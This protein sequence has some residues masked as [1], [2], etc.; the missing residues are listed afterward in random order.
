MKKK[1]VA[2]VLCVCMALPLVGCGGS[3]SKAKKEVNTL[4]VMMVNSGW[5]TAWV[6]DLADKF[7]ELYADEG[8]K[9]NILPAKS[10]FSGTSALSEIRL[11]YE[12]TGYDLVISSGY[13]VQQVTDEEYGVAVEPLTDVMTS[14]PINFDGSLGEAT[15]ESLYDNSQSW[16]LK[17]DD[18]YWAVPYMS[19]SRGL[20]CNMKVLNKYGITEMPV[21]TDEL[22]ECFDTVYNGV[23]D[24]AGMRPVVWGG[25]NAYGYA[26][27]TFYNTIAQ[28][29]G[30]EDYQDFFTLNHL[31]NDD[32]TIKA[33]GYNHLNNEAVKEAIN[34]AMH[35]FDVAYSL[36]GSL[37]QNHTKA[38]ASIITGKAAFMFDGNFF[39]NEVRTS[40]PSYL[41]DVRFSLLPIASKL[42]V[43]LQ[44]DGSG[45][46][47][48]KCDEILS[49]MAKQ[50]DEGKSAAEI[51]TTTEAQFSIALTDEKVAR[52][53]EARRTGNGDDNVLNI[54]KGSPNVEIAKLFIRMMLSEDAAKEVYVKYGMCS[55]TYSNIEV[56][57]EYQ[58]ITDSY[59]ALSVTDF[60]TT[61]TLYPY[62]VRAKTNLFLI[63]PYNAK[64]AVTFK[65]E[66]GTVDKATDRNY[67][68][69]T[70]TIFNKVTST[71]QKN[72]ATYMANG[73]Y[74]IG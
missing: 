11:G 36:A 40:F 69:L 60:R 15:I 54:I 3:E 70:E 33:D 30:R 8:Y 18:T 35:S 9:V 64:F 51:K 68:L 32:G 12:K 46:D 50:V 20:V 67:E 10:T 59:K 22:F 58:F 31:L 39:F 7:E 57:S 66:M 48:A 71:T 62:S 74:S 23:G 21:T 56:N 17:I 37:T 34:V 47:R 61:S 29:M 73:G 72:W 38:H 45:N 13:N 25:D 6:E 1:I 41:K 53:I 14:Q 43:D 26:L 2:S 16:R 5:G 44:L 63:P 19:S 49:S 27:P 42:G 65:D 55:P 4:N 52:V 28:L 24:V